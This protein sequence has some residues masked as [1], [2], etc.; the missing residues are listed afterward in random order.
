MTPFFHAKSSTRHNS[1]AS[2]IPFTFNFPDD[3]TIT[4]DFPNVLFKGPLGSISLYLGSIYVSHTLH[5]L[6]INHSYAKFPFLSKI[7]SNIEI[8]L[9]VGFRRTLIQS[10]VWNQVQFL[11]NHSISFKL[12]FSHPIKFE[13]PKHVLFKSSKDSF[14][15]H[16]FLYSIS[17]KLVADT[18][19]T[20]YNFKP[21]EPYKGTGF[22]YSGQHVLRKIGKKK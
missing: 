18:A 20:L 2:P 10:G 14:E 4:S 3:I 7:I 11:N 9:K 16:I 5:S 15:R 22:R 13:I 17:H 19:A 1:L 6:T 12:G 8:G 21:V